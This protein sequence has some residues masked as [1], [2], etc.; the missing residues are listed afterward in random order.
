MS[1]L[2]ESNTK[3]SVKKRK[4]PLSFI[5]ELKEELKKVSWTTKSEL[6]SAT[7]IVIMSMFGFGIGIYLV[8]LFIKGILEGIKKAAFFIFG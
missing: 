8:D 5:S 3:Q 1:T 2:M 6:F 7:K 4:D